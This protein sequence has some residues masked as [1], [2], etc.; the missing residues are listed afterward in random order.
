MNKFVNFNKLIVMVLVTVSTGGCDSYLDTLPDNR[1]EV[2]TEE[3]VQYLLTSA[4]PEQGYQFVTEFMSDNVDDAGEDNPYTSRFL[5]EVAYWLDVTESDNESP[6]CVW[7]ANYNAIAAANLALE[8][9]DKIVAQKGY[10]TGLRQAKAEAL[11]CRAYGHFNLVNIFA[12]HYSQQNISSPGV[13]YMETSET[14]LSP[15]YERNTVGEVYE[16][17]DADIQAALPDLGTSYMTVPK[18]H[19]NEAAAYAFATRFYLYYEKYD[20]VIEYASRA[21]GL[22]PKSMMKNYKAIG[23]ETTVSAQTNAYIDAA[24]NGNFML[25][26]S[27]S[28]LGLAFGAYYVNKRFAH[29]TNIAATEDIVAAQPWA[30]DATIAPTDYYTTPRGYAATNLNCYIFWRIPYLM[31]MTDPVAGIGY[32]RSVFVQFSGDETLLN[33]AEAYAM[34]KQYDK[35]VADLNIWIS[36]TYKRYREVSAEDIKQFYNNIPYAYDNENGV[37]YSSVEGSQKKHLNPVFSIDA[38]GSV[39]ES[40]I[41]AILTARRIETLHNGIRWFDIKRWGIEIPRRMML[42]NGKPE[43]ICDWL[44]KDDLRRAVQIPQKVVDAGYEANER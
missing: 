15:K 7:Q 39:Q 30:V 17:I 37:K 4:Y 5:N 38:E 26:T 43:K 44:L 10:T 34:L 40:L 42:A 14:T 20:K 32:Y 25:S 28:A 16:R 29:N 13:T 18:Y 27:Y 12:K 21:L 33:R 22:S 31:E 24:D 19:F 1:T 23:A 9:I 35:A 2:D 41:Q 8:S 3:K 6:E 36:N 11:M